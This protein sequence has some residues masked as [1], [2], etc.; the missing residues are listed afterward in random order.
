MAELLT[1]TLDMAREYAQ[2]FVNRRPYTRQ[3]ERPHPE[4][5]RHYYFRPKNGGDLSADFREIQRHLAGEITLG[6]YAINPA[7]QRVKWMAID[8]DYRQALADLLKLQYELQQDGVQAALEQSRRGGHLW[9]FFAEPVLARHARVY[10][11]HLAGKLLVN[12]KAGAADGI[13]L[14]PKQDRLE[15]GQFGNAIRAPL[16][17]HRAV[18]RRYWFY[19]AA[20]SLDAQMQYLRNL[21]RVTEEQLKQLIQ[22]LEFDEPPPARVEPP[23]TGS[24]RSF[25]ILEHLS[26]R[27]KRRVGRNWVTQCPSCAAAGRDRGRDNL[28]ISVGEPHKY[29][30]WAGCT[31]EQIRATLGVP[32]RL[33]REE[34]RQ[35]QAS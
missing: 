17:I 21:R 26:P 19:G 10:I 15:D 2:W 29:I 7:N 20:Y 4:S 8:A 14:F 18:N 16:G 3:S 13:E 11:Q 28:A 22:G 33:V 35:W 31:K 34:R 30:C 6:I 1:A 12:L 24:G 27:P 5:G 9:I 25:I 32:I 23:P